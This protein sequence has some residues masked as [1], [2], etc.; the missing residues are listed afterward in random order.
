MQEVK[1]ELKKERSKQQALQVSGA[2]L[3]FCMHSYLMPTAYSQIR[4]TEAVVPKI[5]IVYN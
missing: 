5:V 2:C 3:E 1:E 4:N